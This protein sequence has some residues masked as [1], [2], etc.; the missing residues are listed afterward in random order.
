MTR[1]C[2]YAMLLCQIIPQVMPVS[3]NEF[4]RFNLTRHNQE[5]DSSVSRL[6]AS[7]TRCQGNPVS[8]NFPTLLDIRLMP[9]CFCYGRLYEHLSDACW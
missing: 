9:V 7:S 5:G 1:K 6:I 3:S 8:A 2:L 4:L